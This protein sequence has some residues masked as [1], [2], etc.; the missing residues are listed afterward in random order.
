MHLSL[1]T[2]YL[3][4]FK[5]QDIKQQ[6]LERPTGA[7]QSIPKIHADLNTVWLGQKRWEWKMELFFTRMMRILRDWQP[8]GRR[9]IFLVPEMKGFQGISEPPH[10]WPELS[11]NSMRRDLTCSETKF[12]P[13]CA[14]G[15]L[16]DLET[17]PHE[18]KNVYGEPKS[19]AI[20]EQMKTDLLM[21]Q[22]CTWTGFPVGRR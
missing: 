18:W 17:D 20:R 19:A 12:S 6:V 11:R 3:P 5:K 4:D 2:L 1:V 15:E 10:K 8:T 21:H 22:A 14:K 7:E 13:D 16:Y 9:Q